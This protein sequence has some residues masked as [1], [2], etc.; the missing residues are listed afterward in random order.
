MYK[1]RQIKYANNSTSIQVFKI[2]NR[3]RVIVRQIGT[4][5]NEQEKLDLLTHANNFIKK[6]SEQLYLF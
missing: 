5:P 4:A 2:E 6:E 1:I 3:K